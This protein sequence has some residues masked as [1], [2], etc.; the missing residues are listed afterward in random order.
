MVASLIG[1]G[2]AMLI[3]ANNVALPIQVGAVGV[4]LTGF[5]LVFIMPENGFHPTPREESQ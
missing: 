1:M 4:L 2:F 3:G 5:V